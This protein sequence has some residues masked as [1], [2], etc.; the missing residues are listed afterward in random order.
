MA[1]SPA[2]ATTTTLTPGQYY[3]LTTA[4]DTAVILPTGM[5]AYLNN[6]SSLPAGSTILNYSAWLTSESSASFDWWGS[7]CTRNAPVITVDSGATLYVVGGPWGQSMFQATG[8]VVF[9]TTSGNESEII[10]NNK[11][12]GNVTLQ[13]G[14]IVQIGWDWSSIN[15]ATTFGPN[16][17]F[18]LQGTSTLTLNPSGT[19]I[20][21]GTIASSSS[22][23]TFF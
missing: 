8:D 21:S 9:E 3:D 16:T 5:T 14:A 1:A 10:G 11:F 17:H 2:L 19:G 12:L 7:C 20:F 15:F 22:T 13:D 6:G 18:V 4:T 23:S